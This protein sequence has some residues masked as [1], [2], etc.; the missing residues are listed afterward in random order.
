MASATAFYRWTELDPA[1]WPAFREAAGSFEAPEELRPRAHAGVPRVALP[2]VRARRLASL[3]RALAGRRSSTRLTEAPLADR[4]LAQL[5]RFAHGALEGR[6]RGPVP[7]AGGLQA[8]ELY[9][10]LFGR[11]VFHYDRAGHHLSVLGGDASRAAWRE[12]VPSLDVVAGGAA[13]W[14]AVGDAARVEA[15]YGPRGLRFLLL[16]AGHLMQNLC[17]LSASLALATVPL[18]GFYERACAGA[19]GLLPAD[20]VLYAGLCGRPIQ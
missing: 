20:L 4:D 15:K 2:K 13:L 17:L 6:G 8:V 14:L 7:S 9:A 5:L 12:R 18:G 11:G 1:T 10:V 19:L 3:D 16:E